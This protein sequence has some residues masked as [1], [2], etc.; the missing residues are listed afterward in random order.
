[1]IAA[2]AKAN[3]QIGGASGAEMTNRGLQN[4]VNPVGKTSTQKELAKIA[5]VS[6]DT[7]RVFLVKGILRDFLSSVP[8]AA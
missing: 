7:I 5:G 4:S 2:K 8:C 3:Q 6:H 1:L